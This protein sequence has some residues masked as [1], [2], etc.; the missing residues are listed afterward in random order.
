VKKQADFVQIH[1]HS[2]YS[3][4]DGFSAIPDM[5]RRAKE[6]GMRACGLTD[7]GTFAG[8]IEFLRTCR[9]E[10]VRPILG[11]EAYLS[12]NHCAHSKDEQPT[13]RRGNRHINLIA[14][15]YIGYQNIC[16]LSQTSSLEGFYY[17]PR[18][19][20]GLLA[21]YS[22]GVIATS[23][24]LS[25]IVN[26][27]LADDK[28]EEAKR[29]VGLFQDI[30]G[31][32]YY[33]EMMFH[34]I[35]REAKIMPLIYKLS[36]ELN[37]KL[38]AT[39]DCHYVNKEDAEFHEVVMCI[40]SGRTLKDPRRLKFPYHEFYFKSEEEMKLIFSDIPEAMT[41]TLEIAEKCDYS[42]I[43]FVEEGGT[44][45]LPTFPIPEEETPLSCLN[46][47]A[48]KGL[49]DLG[50]SD[51]ERHVERLKTELGDIQLIWDTKRYDFATYF[52]IVE[53]MMRFA[54]ENDIDAGIRGSGY[55]SLLLKCLGIVKGAIDPLDFDLLWER[56]LGFDD[57]Y[58]LSEDD[59]ADDAN[60]CQSVL[61]YYLGLTSAEPDSEFTLEKR[62]TYGRSGFPDIDMDFDYMRRHEV[63]EYLI[64]KYGR[65]YVGNIG[66]VQTFKTKAAVRRAI[67]V[68]DPTNS[69]KFDEDG[70]EI[71]GASNE[72][73]ALENEILRTL[74][75]L[76][77]R[78][79]GSAVG[80]VQEAYE[81]YTQFSEY[82]DKYPEIMRIAKGIEGT[83]AGF[84]V[85]AAGILLSPIPLSRI[86]P[87]HVTT[88]HGAAS[89]DGPKKVMATQFPMGDVERLGL[90]KF[91]VL[92]LSTKTAINWACKSIREERDFKV[93]WNKVPLDDQK[94]LELLHSGKTDGCFQLE[95]PGMKECLKQIGIDAFDDLVVAVA[96]YRP[97]PK[98]YIPEFSGR[99]QGRV[100]VSY[101]DPRLKEITEVTHGII[102]YQ[103][104]VMK[105]F[106]VL[107]ELTASD[108]YDF[109][110]GCAK[111]KIDL[112][113]AY[114]EKFFRG[115]LAL[116]IK[117][118]VLNRIWSDL[119]KFSGYAFN[120]SH[121]VSYAY[122]S[123][124]TAYLKA[125]FPTEFISA[126]LSVE[127]IRR[128]FDDVDKYEH[129]AVKNFGFTIVEPDINNSKL[130]WSILDD[131]KL[132]KPMLVK[133]I[134]I[135]AAEE[136][137][138]HQPYRGK[139]LL[140]SFAM[141]VGKAV[142]SKVMEA[143]KDAGFWSGT[144]KEKLIR[145]FE[146]IKQDKKKSRGRHTMD[147]FG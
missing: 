26:T 124:K 41:N 106:M 84:G 24:C 101:A 85:H 115:A 70:K 132:L 143:M 81:E 91:D 133:G 71:K 76:M 144:S 34:G 50:L 29:T 121:S 36:K 114:K 6:L 112:I 123:Y 131:K 33:L 42:E 139:D 56:F 17:D 130:H 55:G 8:A 89:E 18:V 60:K 51:S 102:V 66:N 75:G 54:E 119:H 5:V 136:I 105:A 97:G 46:K 109:M 122:E 13:G 86:A 25:N 35:G 145:N 108:G 38:I 30:Y 146:Q 49:E 127:T 134:G 94:T 98:D 63:V 126:R 73:F 142:T 23:A 100:P 57:K 16:Q 48:W 32:D 128:N 79:D 58:F 95:N 19:D 147:L 80:S 64:E 15:N 135:K 111:K 107:A 3:K 37:V 9:K 45:K 77:K 47:M 65:E 40:S 110:K 1:N 93:D 90:I 59:F 120:K 137:V 72:N 82:M 92:G 44:M 129:D 10:G 12:K 113:D 87:L 96:M 117:E 39:N 69:L 7:H 78:G 104:Q 21:K 88:A 67:K 2:Q 43:I 116:D 141:K 125:H 99:K 68:L 74:P 83:V 138:K 22:E 140:Y 4:F 14:K 53:D 28:Y 20:P 118:S 27:L 62:R 52:L 61:A 103:E 11:M 31:E